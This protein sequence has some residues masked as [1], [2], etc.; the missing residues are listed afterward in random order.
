MI[1][2][3]VASTSLL[4]RGKKKASP[5]TSKNK[6]FSKDFDMTN[7]RELGCQWMGVGVPHHVEVVEDRTT[8]VQDGVD[9]L[10][11]KNTFKAQ[12][13]NLKDA[14]TFQ[15][16]KSLGSLRDSLG[17]PSKWCR[18]IHPISSHLSH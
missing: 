14:D 17:L 2:L 1:R 7:G 16:S 11:Q 15:D 4:L 12:K 6:T 9:P 8:K 10:G 3:I 5:K 18:D 13:E